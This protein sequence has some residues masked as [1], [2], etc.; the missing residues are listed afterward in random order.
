MWLSL[1][2]NPESI[3]SIFLDKPPLLDNVYWERLEI[4]NGQDILCRL[5]FT[6][7]EMPEKFPK[8][9]AKKNVNAIHININLTV[10]EVVFLE[11]SNSYPNGVLTFEPM[12]QHK[13]IVFKR[14]GKTVFVINSKWISI[15]SVI[16]YMRDDF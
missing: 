6:I 11:L 10:A 7:S 15:E 1:I 13:K 2:D 14:E 3:Q 12:G 4:I 8:K 5:S 9:W 16:G